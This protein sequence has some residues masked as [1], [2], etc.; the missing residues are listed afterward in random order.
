MSWLFFGGLGWMA[1]SLL[2][3][4]VF[5]RDPHVEWPVIVALPGSAAFLLGGTGL[6]VELIRWI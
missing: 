4:A 2:A 3:G 1:L 6:L 5:S